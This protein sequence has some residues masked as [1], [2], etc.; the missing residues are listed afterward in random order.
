MSR[1]SNMELLNDLQCLA[2]HLTKRRGMYLI[3][4]QVRPTKQGYYASLTGFLNLGASAV[5]NQQSSPD[6]AAQ[7]ARSVR[8]NG[9]TLELDPV[10]TLV[11]WDESTV[12]EYSYLQS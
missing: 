5:A 7:T 4:P 2:G 9:G 8:S 3:L 10:A 6:N 11:E 1:M 12:N